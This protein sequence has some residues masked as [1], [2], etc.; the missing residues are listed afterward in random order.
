MSKIQAEGLTF[1]YPSSGDLIFENVD[2]QIDTDWRLGF[3][4]RNG[5]GKTT[6]LRLLMGEYEY[7]GRIQAS[8]SFD[9]FPYPVQNPE[10]MTEEILRE[11]CPEA[12]EWEFMKELFGLKMREDAFWRPFETLSNGERTKALLAALFLKEGNFLLIDEPTNHL[13][14]EARAAVAEYLR[15]KKGF[16]LVSHD[17]YFLDLCVDHIM[18]LNRTDIEVRSGNFSSW[19]DAFCRRQE[20]ELSQNERLKKD[21]RRL[22]QSALRTSMWSDQV[23]ASKIGAAD[24]GYVG[25]KSAKMMKRAKSIEARQEKA[26]EEK[27]GLLKNLETAEDL[28]LIPLSYR[29]ELLASF[30]AVSP[31][32]HG[33]PVCEPVSFAVNRGDRIVLDGR[34]GSGKSSLLKL[35]LEEVSERGTLLSQTVSGLPSKEETQ[36]LEHTGRI[37]VGSGLIVSYVSQDTSFLKGSLSEFAEKSGID[38]TLLKAILRKLD[39]GREQFEKGMENFSGGQKKKVLIARSLCE[40]A[41]L[42]V[43]DEPLNFIDIYSRLQIE[44]LILEMRPTLLLVEHDRA[45]RDAAA[46]KTV[47]MEPAA[48]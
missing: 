6:L 7:G 36:K 48:K 2:F 26:M 33:R 8:V 27:A 9:Y 37:L 42:Y 38:E 46:G 41:H 43:W 14:M 25:H 19:M 18:A 16:I 4:G 15:R 12:E 21:I 11:I 5:R 47:R 29:S 13:D 39:F 31:I 1:S 22:K 35:L 17:R 20:A 3:V 28:K 34:N 44:R 32:F 45:F 40:Q 30:E 10:R 24:K 23:E